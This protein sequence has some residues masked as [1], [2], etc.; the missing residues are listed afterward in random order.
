MEVMKLTITKISDKNMFVRTEP[1]KSDRDQIIEVSLTKK[2][3]NTIMG[4]INPLGEF[5]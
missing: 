5:I 3:Y 4:I 1:A 2:Q